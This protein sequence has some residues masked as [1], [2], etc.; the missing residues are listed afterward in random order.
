[1]DAFR[2]GSLSTV[3]LALA[4]RSEGFSGPTAGL[5]HAAA[6]RTCGP[7]DGPA[8]GIIFASGPVDSSPVSSP[9]LRITIAQPLEQVIGHSWTLDQN[10]GATYIAGPNDMETA[11]SGSATITG[12]AADSTVLGSVA[13]WFPT[14]GSIRGAFRAR[15]IDMH[16][17]CG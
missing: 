8:V 14:R 9:Y 4:C 7:A 13:L 12:L 3:L 16:E 5:P 11:T 10:M 17:L 1:M 2:P 6:F 15:W